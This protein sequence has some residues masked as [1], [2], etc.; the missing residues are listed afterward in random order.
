[1]IDM[2]LTIGFAGIG[3]FACTVIVISI[4][5]ADWPN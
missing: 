1:M 5:R 2:L 4:M 3:L